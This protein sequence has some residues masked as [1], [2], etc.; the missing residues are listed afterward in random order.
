MLGNLL[1]QGFLFQTFAEFIS[2]PLTKCIILRHDVDRLPDNSLVFAKIQHDLGI[3][4][5]YYFRAAPQSWDERIIRKIANLGHEIGYHYEDLSR[6]VWQQAAGVRKKESNEKV[7]LKGAIA[8]FKEN[9]ERL[10]KLVQ[11]QTICM[12]GSPMSLWD[13][14]LLWKYY[15][16]RKFGITGEPYFDL[17]FSEVLYLTDTG[18]RWNGDNFNLRDKWFGAWSQKPGVEY[19][20]DWKVKPVMNS[21]MQM[22]KEAIDFQ[23]RYN[24]KSTRDI[25]EANEEDR[26]PDKIMMTFHPQR[27]TNR[28]LPWIKELAWQNTKNIGKYLLIKIRNQ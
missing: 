8:S 22:S 20:S 9:F 6:A 3:K 13:S 27:W 7:I 26:L 24:F 12:H 4:G 19:F 1:H 21:A 23:N 16:Y 10:R 28:P 11:I 25:I 18:R 5:S 14:R 2:K 17:D 15:D